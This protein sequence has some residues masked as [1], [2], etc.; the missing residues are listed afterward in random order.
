MK[1]K[2]IKINLFIIAFIIII[3]ILGGILGVLFTRAYVF[4]DIYSGAFSSELN[5]NDYNRSNLVI[6]DAKKVVVNQDVQVKENA[7]QIRGSMLTIFRKKTNNLDSNLKS[8]ETELEKEIPEL[9][10]FYQLNNPIGIALIVSADG[11]AIINKSILEKNVNFDENFV[12]ISSD[13]DVYEIDKQINIE[14]NSLVLIHLQEA[15]NLRPISIMPSQ[16]LISGQSLLVLNS[17]KQIITNFLSLKQNDNLIKSSDSFDSSIKIYPETQTAMSLPWLFN[18]KG[19]AV[20]VLEEDTWIPLSMSEFAIENA[21]MESEQEEI[22]VPSLGVN[23][24]N[25]SQVAQVDAN[26]Q[27]GALIYPNEDDIAVV[28]DSSADKAGL[29]EG[30]IILAVNSLNL[31]KNLNLSEALLQ[32]KS[33]ETVDLTVSRNDSLEIIKVEL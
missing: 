18:F 7:D 23:Y 2:T 10:N 5:L 22:K 24:I 17:Q 19:Q 6:R 9:T 26:K 11:W 30:D 12:A 8:S 14:K 21:L 15:S 33:G 20:A 25:L 28:K 16:D 32:F 13:R 31:D 29:Q 3:S 1:N 27:S 4:N